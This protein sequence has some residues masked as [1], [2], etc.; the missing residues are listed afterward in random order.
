MSFTP[1]PKISFLLVAGWASAIQAAD[2]PL[3]KSVEHATFTLSSDGK[4]IYVGPW[5]G[6]IAF[7]IC[8]YGHSLH[9]ERRADDQCGARVQAQGGLSLSRY[10]R[11]ER[12]GAIQGTGQRCTGCG[13]APA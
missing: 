7:S 6:K 10:G 12:C 13:S 8:L 11:H 5:A 2:A 3:I 9:H 1:T 4:T